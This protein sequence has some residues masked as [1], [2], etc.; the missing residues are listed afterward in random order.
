MAEYR[1]G[2][3]LWQ[4]IREP[5]TVPPQQLIIIK[6]NKLQN[7]YQVKGVKD[8]MIYDYP[9]SYLDVF[10]RKYPTYYS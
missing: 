6:I 4:N 10:L 8:G 5:N 1:V 3:A 7:V 2:D 9:K